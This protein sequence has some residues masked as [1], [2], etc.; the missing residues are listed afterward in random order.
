MALF[1]RNDPRGLDKRRLSAS[2]GASHVVVFADKKHAFVRVLTS[3]R[4]TWSFPYQ[5]IAYSYNRKC[6]TEYC[7]GQKRRASDIDVCASGICMRLVH[8]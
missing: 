7:C 5:F 6:H 3:T 1:Y 8:R 4:R 2:V